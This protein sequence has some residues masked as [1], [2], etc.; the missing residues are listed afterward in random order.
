[1]FCL[2]N[3]ISS[4]L[5]CWGSWDPIWKNYSESSPIVTFIRSS[6]FASSADLS[7]DNTG[8]FN[9]YKPFSPRAESSASGLCQMAATMHCRAMTWSPSI[10]LI[11]PS[12]GYLT[13][14]CRV[15]ETA[16]KSMKPRSGNNCCIRRVYIYNDEIYL[17]HLRV[18]LHRQSNLTLWDNN[19]SFKTH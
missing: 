15:E 19:L 6:D 12:D 11:W 1:M 9:C 13:F 3:S 10:S 2:R 17:H 5:S 4:S 18:S 14:W 8:G 16:P 7:M